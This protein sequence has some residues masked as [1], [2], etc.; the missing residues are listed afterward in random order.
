MATM[1][2]KG[3]NG[4]RKKPV[5]ATTPPAR[6]AREEEV[7]TGAIVERTWRSGG[8]YQQSLSLSIIPDP[9]KLPRLKIHTPPFIV[10]DHA[11]Q[12]GSMS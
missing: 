11:T 1:H 12:S 10:G 3:K 6:S 4:I 9:K 2:R 5:E 7:S 8:Y